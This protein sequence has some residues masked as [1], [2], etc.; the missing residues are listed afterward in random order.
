MRSLRFYHPASVST[1]LE[2]SSFVSSSSTYSSS[3]VVGSLNWCSFRFQHYVAPKKEESHS[4]LLAF[5]KAFTADQMLRHTRNFGIIAH[6]DAGKTTTTERMLYYAGMQRRIGEVD[7]GTTTT[8][9]MPE[10][11]ERGISITSAAVSFMWN[12][13]RVNLIDTPGHIDFSVEVQRSL[14]VVDGV[15]VVFDAKAG[16]QAQSYTVLQMARKNRAP[17][18]A[19]MNKMDKSDANFEAAVES[20]REKLGVVPLLM[21]LPLRAS[22]GECIGVV[23]LVHQ[24]VVTFEGTQGE[25]VTRCPVREDYL[26]EQLQKGRQALVT[27]LAE[28]ESGMMEKYL[29]LLEEH[30]G[31]EAA[32]SRAMPAEAIYASTRAMMCSGALHGALPEMISPHNSNHSGMGVEEWE[33]AREAEVAKQR[34]LQEQHKR[35]MPVFLG[36]SRRNIGVQTLMDAVVHLLPCPLDR[37]HV[38]GIATDKTPVAAPHASHPKT[39]VFVFKVVHFPDPKNGNALS[40]FVFFRVFSGKVV[41]KMKLYN[42]RTRNQ[43]NMDRL[44]M[45]HADQLCAVTN[46][47]AGSVGGAFMSDVLTGD[48]LA[49]ENLSIDSWMMAKGEQSEGGDQQKQ[50]SKA[51]PEGKSAPGSS[52][53]AASH[54][55]PQFASFEPLAVQPSVLSHAIEASSRHLVDALRGALKR[56]EIEDPS[57][58]VSENQFGQLV[59]SGMGELHLDIVLSRLR[60]EY[61]VSCDL[62]KAF[63]NYRESIINEVL[64]ENVAATADGLTLFT[65]DVLLKPAIIQEDSLKSSRGLETPGA[66]GSCVMPESTRLTFAPEAVDAFVASTSNATKTADGAGDDDSGGIGAFQAARISEKRA[67]DQLVAIRRAVNEALASALKMGP[68]GRIEM[69]GFEI[70]VVAMRRHLPTW[71]PPQLQTASAVFLG[72]L[73]RRIDKQNSLLL[74]PI[75]KLQVHLTDSKYAAD[76]VANLTSKHALCIDIHAPDE[77]TTEI[78]ALVPLRFI[79]K[80]S[81]EA[82]SIAKGNVYFWSELAMLRR[83][84]DKTLEGK[85]LKSLLN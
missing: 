61:S 47:P 42:R 76:I 75:M 35:I 18:I 23:D 51:D 41:N 67:K 13:H 3:V 58:R 2:S 62:T 45:L 25:V 36:A 20:L 26:V 66:D 43:I 59:V 24:T 40:P 69:D 28:N 85:I 79:T 10:E 49:E 9:Y 64:I 56:I 12:S 34:A 38:L 57:L 27:F 78:E 50:K 22:T 39:F 30:G 7:R 70:R 31:D 15:V 16:V 48:T 82:R 73:L 6:I 77:R 11:M 71:D 74:E 81:S 17:A 55:D 8:D 68:L 46:F 37:P 44:H 72:Q 65:A 4:D 33:L 14:R 5:P 60:R 21:Q 83:I 19:F 63:V 53:G 1:L 29:E 52:S 84:T 54:R 32:A 80:Y